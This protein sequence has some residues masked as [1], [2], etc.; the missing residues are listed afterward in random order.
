MKLATSDAELKEVFKLRYRIFNEELGEGI[1]ENAATGLDVDDFDKFCEHL[2]VLDKG[3]VIGTYRLLLGSRRP[4]QGFYTET[5][6]EIKKLPID[7]DKTV[8]LGRG[9]IDIEYRN[10]TTLIAL[11]WG[12]HQFALERDA[13]YMLGCGSLPPMN[14]DDAEATYASLLAAQKV[15]N[16]EG[17]GP[18]TQNAFKG[19]A[20]NGKGDV[21][22]LV[23]FYLEFGA[24][25]FGRPAYDPVF[26]CYDLLIVFDMDHLSDWGTE[27]LA[28]FDRR[29]LLVADKSQPS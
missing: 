20:E 24:Q 22:P 29:L 7:L 5:E 13:H 21:P 1:P 17:V 28:R 4:P 23:G 25:I 6:F 16:I 27:L 12:L 19:N 2:M 14:A 18:R 10:K 8:E 15:K 9:C 11:F 3:K 26:K